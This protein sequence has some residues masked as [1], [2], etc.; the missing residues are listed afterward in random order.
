MKNTKRCPKCQ[1]TEIVLIPGKREEG[2]ADA[3]A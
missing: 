3:K 1:S 2:G